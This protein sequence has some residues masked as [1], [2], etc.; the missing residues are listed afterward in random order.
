[1][2]TATLPIDRRALMPVW[3]VEAKAPRSINLA[4]VTR[5]ATGGHVHTF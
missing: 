2:N 1:M 4:T 3:D 5:I